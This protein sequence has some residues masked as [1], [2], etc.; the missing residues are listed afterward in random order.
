M[1]LH[2]IE[3]KNLTIKLIRYL[4]TGFGSFGFQKIFFD[5]DKGY[6]NRLGI[7]EVLAHYG[8]KP[9]RNDRLKCP[10]HPDKTPTCRCT[11]K[12]TLT[13]ALAATA[14]PAPEMASSL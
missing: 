8:L 6:K 10:F 7:M 9:D 11:P 13:A 5:V 3:K 1:R 4:R 2:K 14:M 12:P